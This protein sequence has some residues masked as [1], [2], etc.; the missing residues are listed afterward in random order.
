MLG[1]VIIT[2]NIPTEVFIAQVNSIKKFCKD[3]Y[4]IIV[5]DNSDKSDFIESI[6]HQVSLDPDI[7]YFKTQASSS[8]GSDSHAFA[9]NLSYS[10][11]KDDYDYLFYLDHDCLPI[12]DFSVKDIL[13]ENIL[14]GIGQHKKVQYIWPG[15]FMFNNSLI[16]HN[17]VDFSANHK[18]E[19]DTGGNLYILVE[20]YPQVHFDEKYV[21]NEQFTGLR[22]N[23]YALIYQGTFMHFING[24]QWN[25]V[26]DNQNRI[27]SLINIHKELTGV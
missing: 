25:L 1:I 22:Y 26:K 6:A 18:L 5:F 12:K 16:D 19:T 10:F 8:G 27:N 20:K 11:I 7:R 17:L 15:C 24:S 23:Y 13:G 3:P 21:Q 2:F 9:A 4:Q 14:G